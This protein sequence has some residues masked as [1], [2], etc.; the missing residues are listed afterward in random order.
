M[1]L[2]LEF[3]INLVEHVEAQHV[4]ADNYLVAVLQESF[5][6]GEPVQQRAIGRTKIGDAIADSCVT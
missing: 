2:L 5:R 4:L 1:N 3:A 6:D